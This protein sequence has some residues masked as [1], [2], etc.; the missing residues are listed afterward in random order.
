MKKQ[1]LFEVLFWI[2]SK[3][4]NEG[5]AAN[6]IPI[7]ISTSGSKVKL[8]M[9]TDGCWGTSGIKLPLFAKVDSCGVERD[10]NGVISATIYLQD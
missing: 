5:I 7:T 1:F 3:I 10:I 9:D 2:R 8:M 6:E 4:I